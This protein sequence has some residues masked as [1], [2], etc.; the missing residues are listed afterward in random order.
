[1]VTGFVVQATVSFTPALLVAGAIALASGG[2][3]S[4][5]ISGRG[6]LRPDLGPPGGMMHG[7]DCPLHGQSRSRH[8]AQAHGYSLSSGLSNLSRF[9]EDIKMVR[10][11]SM[12]VAI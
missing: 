5:W 1:M 3:V 9:W 11:M 10:L 8:V 7:L 12:A 4:G 2:G 6:D